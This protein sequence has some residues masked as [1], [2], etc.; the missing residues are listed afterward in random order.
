[1]TSKSTNFEGELNK[2]LTQGEKETLEPIICE[3]KGENTQ[4]RMEEL[5]EEFLQ[6]DREEYYELL[7]EEKILQDE[8][9]REFEILSHCEDEDEKE[10][11]KDVIENIKLEIQRNV[12]V[13]KQLFEKI[14]K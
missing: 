4:R 12:S 3:V 5:S 9:E 13:Q 1:M 14:R 6:S 8:L 7:D 11:A 10:T 2:S